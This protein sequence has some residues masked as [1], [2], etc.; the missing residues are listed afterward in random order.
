MSDSKDNDQESLNTYAS[1]LLKFIITIFILI[2]LVLCYFSSGALILFIC[3][4]AQ[5][6]ILPSDRNCAP[7]TDIKP[8][9][10]PS[11]IVTNIFTTFTNP[12]MSMK[13]EIPYDINSKNKMLDFFKEYKEKSSSNFLANYFITII[14]SL[15]QFNN[16]SINS[17][18][19]VVN[20]YVPELGIILIGPI[21]A[22]I[23]YALG[24]ICNFVYF[25]I[26]W[27]YCMSWFFKTNINDT[28]SGKPEWEN[29]TLF[30]PYYF[31]IGFMLVILF[32]ILFFV[33]FPFVSMIPAIFFHRSLIS[34][35]FYKGMMNG[36][37]AT[38]FTIAK[39]TLKHYK[40]TIVTIVSILTVLSAFSTLG[41]IP[42]VFSAITLALIYYGIISIDI[43]KAL[44]EK[45]LSPL[46]S[47]EQAV[48]KCPKIIESHKKKHGFLYFLLFGLYDLFF[49][50][51]GGE[52]TQEI[53]KIGK[54]L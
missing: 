9:I 51:K 53:K 49:G 38:A 20:S 45:N 22:G 33:G 48:K 3:K 50:Q 36:K 24:M 40:V 28:G 31:F 16:Y 47:Y 19:N 30:S 25:S 1:N 13:L 14:E 10:E 37:E 54:Q 21:I 18:M 15:I 2:I 8:I 29:V 26:L 27:F 41:A 6:N 17:T 42:G 43:F 34:A 39:E 11:P 5:S 4:I 35:F 7:F 46:V 52:M 32:I 44:P 23:L 12:E